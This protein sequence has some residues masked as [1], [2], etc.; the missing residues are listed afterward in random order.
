LSILKSTINSEEID[1]A[2]QERGRRVK[3]KRAGGEEVGDSY[4]RI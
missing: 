4:W 1:M 3:R 2:Y